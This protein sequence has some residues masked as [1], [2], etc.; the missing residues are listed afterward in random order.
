MSRFVPL[1][2]P[3]IVGF[4]MSDHAL[5]QTQPRLVEAEDVARLPYPGTTIPG[6]FS[7]SPDGQS[8]SYLKAESPGSLSRVL[9]RTPIRGGE[10][11]NV[12]RP[13]GGGDTDTNVSREEALRRERQRLRDTGITQIDWAEKTDRAV[14]PLK[15]DLYLVEVD[16][17][18]RRL[19]ETTAPDIDPKLS[20]D[21]SRVAFVRDG[22]LY[23]VEIASGK[24]TRLTQ[25]ATDGLTHGL[26]E[27]MAQEE[28][29][30]QTGFW[31]SPDGSRIAYQETDERHI[32]RY[33]IVHQ[34]GA[35]LSV[36]THRYPFPGQ[37]NA[38]VRLG[39]IAP[40]TGDTKW[41]YYA[42]PTED[43]YLARV[44]WD[45]PGA[46]LV[47]V[48]SRD[49]KTLRLVRIDVASG[50]RRILL[51][52]RSD[53]W[54]NLHND[55]RV[56]KGTGEILWS[57]ERSGFR[58]IELHDADGKLLRTLT[59]GEWAV[60]SVIGVDA[61]RREV[62]FTAGRESP[63]ES[64]LYRV[65]LDGGPIVRV[66]RERG[67]HRPALAPDAEHFVD[68]HSS[69]TKPWVTT[70]RDRNGRIINTL[71]D[72]AKDPRLSE[73]VLAPPVVTQFKSRDGVTLYG[74]YYAPRSSRSGAKA[75]LV[76][77]TYGGPHVQVVADTWG[78][79]SNAAAMTADL[80][81][82]Y[83]T[84]L[85]FAVWK[86]DNR[87]SA[88]R[89][90]AFESA[91]SR[92]MG[93]IEV[94]DQVDGIRFV[95]A[96]WPEVDTNRVGV[97]GG[98]Y[99]GYMTLRCLTESPDTF[100]AG[101]SVAPVTDW[102]GY[103]TCYTERYMGTPQNNPDGY[104]DSSVLHRVAPLRGK[105]LVIHGMLDENVHFRHS[106][107]LTTALISAN[108][109]FAFLPLPDERHSSRKIEDRKYVAEKMGAFFQETL[110][111]N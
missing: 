104:R 110:Q 80:S 52:D 106:A 62:W 19:T 81:A 73:L 31:W 105:L 88:R 5:G 101:V 38:K 70:I 76:V 45:G 109:P 17:P 29:G 40:D 34:G 33:T 64:Q 83:L 7:F 20:S 6:S 92:H 103:D 63:L 56:I 4:L 107:R 99:G 18:L 42:D 96:S 86:C 41:L 50:Q 93:T 51:E 12:A 72:A 79:G 94:R 23:Q 84:G 66:T 74:A 75:P 61:K 102:D 59:A 85:G 91:L 3:I 14:I 77:I 49:Q 30:R 25:G 37:A 11:V 90:L 21:G 8:V 97:T 9:W 2:V 48:L 15:G 108:K 43:V 10:P 53:S 65:S 57:S 39:V 27:F 35:E 54:V 111:G 78:V 71:D 68:V 13:P 26:A 58:H 87:G 1:A 60:D 98:S 24:E 67:T 100:H 44:D 69:R 32:P 55:L 22:D 36:E 47:Q 46:V 28:M 82:H 89:G 95:A 16:K